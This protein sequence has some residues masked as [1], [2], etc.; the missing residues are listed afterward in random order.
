MVD[1]HD[2]FGEIIR[3]FGSRALL[4]RTDM[5][6]PCSCVTTLNAS[7][8]SDCRMCLGTGWLTRAEI[9]N[10]RSRIASSDNA[11]PKT[12]SS[13]VVG[14]LAYSRREFYFDRAITPRSKDLLVTCTWCG[15]APILDETATIFEIVNVDRLLGDGGQVEY[16]KV[17]AGSKPINASLRLASLRRNISRVEYYVALQRGAV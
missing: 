14:E 13:S 7:P 10:C 4:L 3:D 6:S 11:L 5:K 1:L 17:S 12:F 8:R 9:V 2:E 16:I 15:D